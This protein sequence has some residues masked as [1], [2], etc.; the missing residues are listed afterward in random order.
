MLGD[1]CPDRRGDNAPAQQGDDEI[2]SVPVES[3]QKGDGNRERDE[4]L[5]CVGRTDGI[6]RR[7]PA[8]DEC[9]R[10]HR[11]PTSAT[12]GIEKS[13]D[14]AECVARGACEARLTS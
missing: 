3:E 12:D 9:R 11:P 6:T 4:E 10:S 2:E 8:S 1:P 14:P 7:D 5:G 13:G